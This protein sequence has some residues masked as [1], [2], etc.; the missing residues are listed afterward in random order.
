MF[1]EGDKKHGFHPI[2]YVEG[3]TCL[4]EVIFPTLPRRQDNFGNGNLCMD[5][6]PHTGVKDRTSYVEIRVLDFRLAK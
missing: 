3:M 1:F 2:D 6:R 5:L 4:E